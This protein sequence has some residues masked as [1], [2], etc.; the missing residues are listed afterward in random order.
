MPTFGKTVWSFSSQRQRLTGGE[1]DFAFHFYFLGY[2]A[3]VI[4]SPGRMMT[5]SFCVLGIVLVV[6]IVECICNFIESFFAFVVKL[7]LDENGPYILA[8]V[9]RGQTLLCL[10]LISL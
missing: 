3:M 9:R 2:I 5:Y 1:T 4:S 6:L 10:F 8:W 7:V